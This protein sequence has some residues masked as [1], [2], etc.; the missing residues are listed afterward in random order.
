MKKFRTFAFSA[1]AATLVALLLLAYSC[2]KET[3]PTASAYSFSSGCDYL[4]GTKGYIVQEDGIINFQN[5]TT[6]IAFVDTVPTWSDSAFVAWETSLGSNTAY[7]NY[8][9]ADNALTALMTPYENDTVT[10]EAAFQPTF[11]AFAQSKSHLASITKEGVEPYFSFPFYYFVN[12]SGIYR[13]CNQEYSLQGSLLLSYPVGK[14]DLVKEWNGQVGEFGELSVQQLR[15]ARSSEEIQ[16][17]DEE[18]HQTCTDEYNDGK[19]RIKVWWD[20]EAWK[21][22]FQDPNTPPL[23]Q[24]NWSHQALIKAQKKSLGIWWNDTRH[25]ALSVTG[26][27]TNRHQHQAI[28]FLRSYTINFFKCERAHKI[29]QKFAL[30]ST[31]SAINSNLNNFAMSLT[32]TGTNRRTD[33]QTIQASCTMNLQNL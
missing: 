24:Y 33:C 20:S 8:I 16:E 18:L 17:R 29:K 3:P 5:T 10:T 32:V 9:E 19:K 13:I 6:F 4:Y 7:G 22:P 25:I 28:P 2:Q 11:N 27:I 26:T 14:Q 15:T 1:M 21:V 12:Q 31:V 23:Y 30:D